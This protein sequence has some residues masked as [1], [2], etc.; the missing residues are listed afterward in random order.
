MEFFTEGT[1][2]SGIIL[3]QNAVQELYNMFCENNFAIQNS[4]K[5]HC[6]VHFSQ[7]SH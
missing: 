5:E 6:N 1:D 7:D 2:L 4:M 3:G